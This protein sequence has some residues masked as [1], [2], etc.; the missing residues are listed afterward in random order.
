MSNLSQAI[1]VFYSFKMGPEVVLAAMSARRRHATEITTPID[2]PTQI[3]Y[4]RSV[5]IFR[6]SLAV[7]KLFECIDLAGNVAFGFQNLGFSGAFGP[8]N[9]ISY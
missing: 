5:G 6:L 8:P 1:R 3:L 9:V 4:R 2:S 7:K